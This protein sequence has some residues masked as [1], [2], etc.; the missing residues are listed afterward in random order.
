MMQKICEFLILNYL[1][2]LFNAFVHYNVCYMNASKCKGSETEREGERE[3]E[4]ERVY[5]RQKERKRTRVR[6]GGGFSPKLPHDHIICSVII[7]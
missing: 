4:R 2:H 3:N 7:L 5:V 6:C 1:L